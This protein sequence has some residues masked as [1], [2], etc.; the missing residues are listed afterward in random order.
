[1][2]MSSD[3][4]IY[5]VLWAL[6]ATSVDGTTFI[7]LASE[8]KQDYLEI[9]RLIVDREE[10]SIIHESEQISDGNGDVQLIVIDKK[11][12]ITKGRLI[13]T[14]MN[15]LSI[16]EGVSYDRQQEVSTLRF[17]LSGQL[18]PYSLSM[19]DTQLRYIEFMIY[20]ATNFHPV[21]VPPLRV[22]PERTTPK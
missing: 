15:L 14:Y 16:W 18:T 6:I 20:L 12:K 22:L 2:H 21:I 10:F 1:M 11:K 13:E 19:R 5:M 17:D 7:C 8:L 9:V 3:R 4:F